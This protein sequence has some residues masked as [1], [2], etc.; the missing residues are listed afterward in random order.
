M[1]NAFHYVMS[2]SGI[3][4]ESSYPY[5]AVDDTCRFTTQNI[6]A[7][8]KNWTYVS[9]NETQ[10]AATLVAQGPISIAVDANMWQFYIGGIFDIPFCGTSLDHGVL[11][12]GYATGESILGEVPYWIIKNSWA[13]D[14]GED[15]YIY[16]R[17]GKGM[18]GINEF[19]CTSYIN[20][21]K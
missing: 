19:P 9:H 5:E 14:W 3:D 4:T 8:I 21:A 2:K 17:S 12:V 7:S 20:L 1:P 13:A 16:M 10:M 6:G 18:C 15:G 11:I